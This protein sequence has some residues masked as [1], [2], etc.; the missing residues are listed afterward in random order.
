L[1]GERVWIKTTATA[2]DDPKTGGGKLFCGRLLRVLTSDDD[3]AV[4]FLTGGGRVVTSRSTFRGGRVT[5]SGDVLIVTD[6][7]GYTI[8]PA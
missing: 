8:R 7:Y 2:A 4:L 3:E 6:F 5:G 1:L